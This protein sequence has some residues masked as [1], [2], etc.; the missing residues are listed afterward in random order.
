MNIKLIDNFLN[1]ADLVDLQALDLKKIKDNEIKVY[2]NAINTELKILSNEVL[3]EKFITKLHE[4]YHNKAINILNELCPEKV[5]LYEYSEFHIIETGLNYKFP[6][7]DDIPDKLLSGVIY[8][9]PEKNTGTLFYENK[10]GDGKQEIEWKKNRAVFFSRKERKSW[11]SY[12]GDGK[13]NRLAL[14]Y[15]LM[16]TRNRLKEVYKI[17]KKNYLIGMLRYKL[18]PYIFRY[19]RFL[20]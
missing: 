1:N 7:H 20:I 13:S 2:H 8:V 14:V 12:Q 11:H 5:K 6:I 3:S 9:S 15:N 18:N 19:L 4:N 10:K 16:T 17:E